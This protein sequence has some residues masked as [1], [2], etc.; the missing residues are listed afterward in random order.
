LV[1]TEHV[2]YLKA[3]AV[4][5]HRACA[6]PDSRGFLV[7]IEHARYLTAEAVSNHRVWALPDS[8]GC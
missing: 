5:N 3:E 4:S 6:L 1:T 8:R 2:R 7:T